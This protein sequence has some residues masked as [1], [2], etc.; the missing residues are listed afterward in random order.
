MNHQKEH[1]KVIYADMKE[2]QDLIEQLSH[3][4]NLTYAYFLSN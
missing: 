3:F 2:I 1:K 4:S